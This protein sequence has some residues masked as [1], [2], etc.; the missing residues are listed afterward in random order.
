MKTRT[1]IL[2]VWLLTVCG[3]GLLVTTIY[4]AQDVPWL[5]QSVKVNYTVD[6]NFNQPAETEITY[7]NGHQAKTNVIDFQLIDQLVS[8]KGIVFAIFS[9]RECT[10]C[11]AETAL[12]LHPI[13]DAVYAAVGYP[14]P[15]KHY[16]RENN[17]VVAETRVFYGE[18]LSQQPQKTVL[19]HTRYLD[20]QKQWHNALES[21][22]FND[23]KVVHITLTF[24]PKTLE[25]VESLRN[26]GRC[27]EVYS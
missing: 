19:F 5:I 9:G 13:Q 17:T 7:A 26:S 15:G 27:F 22:Q 12:Y 4:A 24:Q 21:L 18:C 20:D 6:A 14:Y 3:C 2:T 1:H 25:N 16:N 11:D 23:E 8:D 10:E